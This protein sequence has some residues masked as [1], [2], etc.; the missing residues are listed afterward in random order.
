MNLIFIYELASL[1][2][3]CHK[4]FGHVGERNDKPDRDQPGGLK[5]SPCPAGQGESAITT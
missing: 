2:R 3:P 4:I 5:K 1:L